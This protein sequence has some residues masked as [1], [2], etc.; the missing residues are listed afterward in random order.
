MT[1]SDDLKNKVIEC[2][3]SHKYKIKQILEVFQI[4]NGTLFNWING[5]LGNLRKRVSKITQPIKDF[6]NKYIIR[7]ICFNYHTLI[8]K[9]KLFFNLSICK[10]T[11]FNILKE[12]KITR[13]KIN[14]RFV[15]KSVLHKFKTL[16]KD[17]I[18]KIN[19]TN[20]D[21][22]SIDE[23]SIDTHIS[24]NYGW[25]KTG[26]RIKRIKTNNRIRYTLICA[27]SRNKIEHYKIIKNSSDSKIFT[28]FI[29]ELKQKTEKKK[30]NILLDNARIHHSKYLK[31]NVN[32][33]VNF[34]YNIPYTPEF[35]P[36]EQMF[37]K[38]KY[39]L[40]KSNI[41]NKNILKNITS[42]LGK[43]NSNDLNGYFN[44]SFK[45]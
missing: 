32:K 24:N 42:S 1:F 44:N 28:N 12:M 11:L 2:Y 18:K 36:I 14:L 34:I 37:S 29:N 41:T 19:N 21:I 16:R 6:I 10:S 8:K 17:L 31:E 25:S 4:S 45:F 33:D 43:I 26:R 13:K 3:N 15:S 35:N 20:G 5:K 9:I 30:I 7:C 39:L 23:S 22:I 38:L 40:R 27:I